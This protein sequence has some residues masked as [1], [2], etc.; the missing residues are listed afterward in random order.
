MV[1]RGVLLRSAPRRLHIVPQISLLAL[2]LLQLLPVLL[3]VGHGN[4]PKEFPFFLG[5][6][7]TDTSLS[8]LHFL[9]AALAFLF[10][11]GAI[12]SEVVSAIRAYLAP[13]A[14]PPPPISKAPGPSVGEGE[15]AAGR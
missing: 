7:F 2:L 9:F 12:L 6:L 8:L 14:A 3:F 5:G 1:L 15:I 13:R 10:G 11:L 4:P